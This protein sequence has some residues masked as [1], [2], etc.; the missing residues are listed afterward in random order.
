MTRL[1]AVKLLR[2]VVDVVGAGGFHPD[3]PMTDYVKVST[4]ERS[5][6]PEQAAELQTKLDAAFGILGEDAYSYAYLWAKEYE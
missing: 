2:E 6:T 1:D 3:T 5:F 4:G